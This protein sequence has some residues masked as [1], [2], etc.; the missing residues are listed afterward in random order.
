MRH[1]ASAKLIV[2][3]KLPLKR[4]HDSYP[5]YTQKTGIGYLDFIQLGRFMLDPSIA[6]LT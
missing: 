4:P 2:L 6:N 3:E 5:S 1:G